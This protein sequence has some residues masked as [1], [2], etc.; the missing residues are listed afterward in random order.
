[1]SASFQLHSEPDSRFTATTRRST[2]VRFGRDRVRK[3]PDLLSTP[4]MPLMLMVANGC[5]GTATMRCVTTMKC[6]LPP[7]VMRQLKP[8]MSPPLNGAGQLDSAYPR[9]VALKFA[10]DHTAQL[11]PVGRANHF[12]RLLLVQIVCKP[13]R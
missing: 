9:D 1:M 2:E 11:Y 3:Q 13:I 8:P 5:S 12:N 4:S 10:S 7:L 6:A